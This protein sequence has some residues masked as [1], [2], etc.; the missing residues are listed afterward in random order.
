MLLAIIDT[1]MNKTTDLITDIKIDMRII[2]KMILKKF[3]A[4]TK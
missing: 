1:K 4:K 3:D 2:L